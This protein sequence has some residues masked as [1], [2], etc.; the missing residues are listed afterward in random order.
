M[1]R[2]FEINKKGNEGWTGVTVRAI[3]PDS[4]SING[5]GIEWVNYRTCSNLHSLSRGGLGL[6]DSTH[7]ELDF[8]L[9]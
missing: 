2:I 4:S 3:Y 6:K 5:S 8:G 1:A 7:M 9:G